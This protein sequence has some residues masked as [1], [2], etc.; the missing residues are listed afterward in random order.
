MREVEECV[1]TTGQRPVRLLLDS[2]GLD[3]RWCVVHATHVAADEVRDLAAS[4]ATVALC[5][6]TEADL[7]DGIFP[8]AEYAGAGGRW[9]IG[10]D[11]HL[12]RAPV[13]ELPLLQLS[14]RLRE[15]PRQ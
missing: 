13:V 9:T 5:P 14:Q 8:F 3:S 10:G 12:C 11:S 7:G 15:Q 2:V 4:G 1:A 6:S